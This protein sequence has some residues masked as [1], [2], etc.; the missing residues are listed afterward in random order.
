MIR[1]L[2]YYIQLTNSKDRVCL[3][4]LKGSQLVKKFP[5]FYG[6][7]TEL[8][9][10]PYPQPNQS[11]P[12]PPHPNSWRSILISAS[13]LCLVLPSAFSPSCF[14]TKTLYAPL[15]SPIHVC[16]MSCPPN[17]CWFDHANIWWGV[18]DHKT[19]HCV[20]FS[21]PVTLS[22]LGPNIFL[23]TLFLNTL[24]LYSSFNMRTKFH[25]HTKQEAQL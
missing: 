11:S 17:S 12:C 25:T 8:A 20:F 9:T 1:V 6:T 18:R 21:T 24:S 23:S 14:L 13:H 2:S 10:C 3:G 5:A 7:Q 15:L 16:Y 19:P 4:K 22:L